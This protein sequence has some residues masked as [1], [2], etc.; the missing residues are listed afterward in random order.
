MS[1][2]VRWRTAAVRMT[3]AT[4]WTDTR[5]R[6]VKATDCTTT[7]ATVK[8]ETSLALSAPLLHR[9]SAQTHSTQYHV[10]TEREHIRNTCS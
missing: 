1:T 8:V 6:V 9:R 5:A 3:A 4:T 10:V 2:S 7:D